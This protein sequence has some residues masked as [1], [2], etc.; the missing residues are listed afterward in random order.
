MHKKKSVRLPLTHALAWI[1]IS[2][3]LVNG[4]AYSL[5]KFYHNKQRRMAF[6]PQYTLNSLIQTGPQREVL[7]TTYL[8]EWIGLSC[9]RPCSALSLNLEKAKQRL[10]RS[11]LISQAE[12]KL[13][14]PNALYIDYTVRQ[15][16]AWLEDY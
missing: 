13:I 12:L 16:I 14:K 10:L 1:V 2:T 6:D 8:A 4:S 15:P 11:P 3:L 5:L 9:D 7:K